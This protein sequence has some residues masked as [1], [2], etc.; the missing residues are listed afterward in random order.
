MQRMDM[1]SEGCKVEIGQSGEDALVGMMRVK[2][3]RPESETVYTFMTADLEAIYDSI[4]AEVIGDLPESPD[5]PHAMGGG[6]H[7]E[8]R[9]GGRWTHDELNRL[10]REV[11]ERRRILPYD[12]D[13]QVVC[14]DEND[15]VY[16]LDTR[17][18]WHH[19]T[20]NTEMAVVWDE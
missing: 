15:A 19:V 20:D 17:H 14:I 16:L 7:L 10:V 2:V 18:E 12:A 3:A 11:R 9:D 13:C 6:W 8:H 5:P 4:R 1:S